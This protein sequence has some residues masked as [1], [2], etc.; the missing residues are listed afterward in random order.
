MLILA[1]DLGKYNSM[2]CFYDTNTQKAEFQKAATTR[3]YLT[4]VFKMR[5]VGL[6]VMEACGPSGWIHDLC[7]E[8]GL[9]NLSVQHQ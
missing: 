4:T 5:E 6:V 2:C 1:I 8:L 7:Q 3:R 9:K